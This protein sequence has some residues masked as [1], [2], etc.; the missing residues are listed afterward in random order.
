[1]RAEEL[2]RSHPDWPITV[3]DLAKV[4]GVS[5]RTLFEGFRRFRGTTPMALLR[6]VRLEQAH[7]ELKAAPPTENIAAIAFKWGLVHLGRFAHDYRAR[8]GELPS[9]TLRNSRG[10]ELSSPHTRSNKAGRR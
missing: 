9:D 4:S 3:G 8:F 6:T 2:I 5:A 10:R 7:A 1:M